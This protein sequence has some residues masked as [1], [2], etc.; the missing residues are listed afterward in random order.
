MK[1]FQVN[2]I[3]NGDRSPYIQ[4]DFDGI[5]LDSD[6]VKTVLT[7]IPGVDHVNLND[8]GVEKYRAIVYPTTYCMSEKEMIELQKE[9]N[10]TLN[11]LL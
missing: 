4:V 10:N 1:F 9:I 5:H 11:R 8:R 3:H 2:I 7:D 6:L